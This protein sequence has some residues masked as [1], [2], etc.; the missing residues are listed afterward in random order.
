MEAG[1]ARNAFALLV[2]TWES[3]AGSGVTLKYGNLSKTAELLSGPGAAI[4][5]SPERVQEPLLDCWDGR[6]P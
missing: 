2:A 6:A 5:T 3:G 4:A 1:V